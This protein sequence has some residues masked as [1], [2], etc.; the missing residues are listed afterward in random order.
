MRRAP[1]VAFLMVGVVLAGC[2][3]KTLRQDTTYPVKG[4]ILYQGQPARFVI[5]RF[6]PA[7]DKG[8]EAVG[9]TDADGYFELRT[10]SNEGNDGGVPGEYKV[11]IEPF[12]PVRGGPLPAGAKPTAIPG[13]GVTTD[14]TVEIA[15][16]DN[17]LTVELP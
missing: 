6:E 9:R 11:T 15:A 5:V 4:R 16:E 12:N 2:G 10:F 13:A 17:D 3:Q 14:G 8:A 7:G 1:L